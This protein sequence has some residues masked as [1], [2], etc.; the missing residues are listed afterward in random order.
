MRATSRRCSRGWDHVCSSL[1]RSASWRLGVGCNGDRSQQEAQPG[2]PPALPPAL[3]AIT[4][5]A[6]CV[7]GGGG[8][9]GGDAATYC[10]GPCPATLPNPHLGLLVRCCHVCKGVCVGSVCV[11]LP[12]CS[13][14]RHICTHVKQHTRV[15]KCAADYMHMCP[16]A[17]WIAGTIPAASPCLTCPAAPAAPAAGVQPRQAQDEGAHPRPQA[18][19][20]AGRPV[21][22]GPPVRLHLQPPRPVRPLR[23][24][25]SGGQGA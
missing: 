22:H 2:L 14:H 21:H 15:C 1:C 17:P 20:P 9:G 10:C 16:P 4:A 12:C 23:R 18:G 19:L 3:Q 6:A 24:L 8:G 5:A 7:C 13:Q 25:H 11:V